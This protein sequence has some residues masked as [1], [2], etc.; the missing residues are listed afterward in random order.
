MRFSKSLAVAGALGLAVLTAAPA[1]AD[2]IPADL[3]AAVEQ[4]SPAPSEQPSE[5][6]S[7]KPAEKPAARPTER[8]TPPAQTPE[9]GTGHYN[10]KLGLSTYEAKAGQQVTARVHTSHRIDSA[11]FSSDL[12]GTRTVKLDRG[13]GEITFTVP[14]KADSGTFPV[15][16][17]AGGRSD[18]ANLKVTEVAQELKIGLS[19]YEAKA[20]QQV[21]VRAHADSRAGEII[22]SSDLFG[23]KTV[24][25]S[26]DSDGYGVAEYTFTVPAQADSGTFDV[27]ADA[28]RFGKVSTRLKV[29]EVAS[30]EPRIGMKHVVVP[31]ESVTVDV[32]G[33]LRAGEAI[34]SGDAFERTYTV[35]LKDAGKGVGRATFTAVIAKDAKP[36]SSA[37]RADFGRWGKAEGSIT[38][39]ADKPVAFGISVS[40]AAVKAGERVTYTVTGKAADAYIE[41]PAFW[42]KITENMTLGTTRTGQVATNPGAKP[43][44]YPVFVVFKD[45]AGAEVGRARTSVTIKGEQAAPSVDLGLEPR[46]VVA[47]QSYHAGVTTKN[48]KPG[49]LVTFTDPGGKRHYARTD[50]YGTARVKLTAPKGTKPGRYTVTAEVAGK[51]DSA[52]LTVVKPAPKA[53]V[54]LE[55]NPGSVVAGGKFTAFVATKHVAPGTK[56]VIVD[57]NGKAFKVSVNRFGVAA[58]RFHV[59]SYVKAGGYWFKAYVNGASDADKLTV[60]T[61]VVAQSDDFTPKGGAATGGGLAQNNMA[62]VALGGLLIAGGAGSAVWGRRKAEQ[63]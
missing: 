36:G 23:A 12:F 7:G 34:V 59:P 6:P 40:P 60:R 62:G 17:T 38:V 44:T 11:T 25:L 5:Q 61:R 50:A 57:P 24:P 16:V 63:A 27:R 1:M 26:G 51:R 49:S 58:K 32:V 55:L 41:S 29:T 56:V 20:G 18:S 43:G 22:F 53:Q 46:A 14:A 42:A 15:T 39:E 19:T 47:G 21:T 2:E 3:A 13:F 31:G 37:V 48:V 35:P 45:A 4:Q 10:V 28:N 8:P 54:N 33:D 30:I 9:A 52:T